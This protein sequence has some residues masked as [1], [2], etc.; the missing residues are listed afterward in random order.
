MAQKENQIPQNSPNYF[1]YIH[2]HKS[3]FMN[4]TN[5]HYSGSFQEESIKNM[6]RE[7]QRKAEKKLQYINNS[8]P[9]GVQVLEIMKQYEDFLKNPQSITMDSQIELNELARNLNNN[10]LRSEIGKLLKKGRDATFLIDN[11]IADTEKLI[12]EMQKVDSGLIAFFKQQ[13]SASQSDI[14]QLLNA[15]NLENMS[16]LDINTTSRTAMESIKKSLQ[17]LKNH[18]REIKNNVGEIFHDNKNREKDYK[19]T[20]T[21]VDGKRKTDTVRHVI[22]TISGNINNLKGGIGEA[23]GSLFAI[24]RRDNLIKIF[25]DGMKQKL[26][27]DDIIITTSNLG[28][29]RNELGSVSK[30]DLFISFVGK[31]FSM[32]SNSIDDILN[33]NTTINISVKNKP[34]KNPSAHK[35]KFLETGLKQLYSILSQQESQYEYIMSNYLSLYKANIENEL[36]YSKNGFKDNYLFSNRYIAARNFESALS[37]RTDSEA[38]TLLAFSNRIITINQYYEQLIN[39]KINQ[40]P[41]IRIENADA[42][43]KANV[44]IP[45][46]TSLSPKDDTPETKNAL[47][48]SRSHKVHGELDKLNK[49]R[50]MG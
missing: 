47:A 42:P 34:F 39:Y 49:A 6:Y 40:L 23:L 22:G 19:I 30:S 17:I 46:G 21:D 15:T 12:D 44:P 48:L 27:N 45:E 31:N 5:Q 41:E 14:K 33:F 11:Y 50:I 25:E 3:T 9:D 13:S 1:P 36:P 18:E 28:E 26:N 35:V 43:S 8:L 24:E 38:I 29:G 20:Y 16:I 2:A 4:Y 37:G 10:H 32:Q 7:Y